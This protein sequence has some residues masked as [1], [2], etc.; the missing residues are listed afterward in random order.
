MI[1][2]I[3]KIISVEPY[4]IVCLWNTN[5]TRL[6]DFNIWIT[7]A[8]TKPNSILYKL[9]NPSI[10]LSV[11]LDEEQEN[12]VWPNLLPMRDGTGIVEYAGL[13]FSPDI[14]YNMSKPAII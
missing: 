7:D 5:E 10:F 11:I 14:L 4:K 2:R 6:I 12:I 13:D 9:S 8:S 1:P 3:K